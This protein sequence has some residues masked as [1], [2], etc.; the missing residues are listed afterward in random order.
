MNCSV[1]TPIG[2]DHDKLFPECKASVEKAIA[3]SKGPFAEIA[4]RP[5][6]DVQGIKGR[7]ASRNSEVVEAVADGAAG[8][9][10]L[11]RMTLSFQ[12]LL[13]R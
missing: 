13:R 10:S 12:T 1:I 11:M 5:I 2:P 9:F 6:D 7:S 4:H 8:F 3:T